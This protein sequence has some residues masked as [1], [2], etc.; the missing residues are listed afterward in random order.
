MIIYSVLK[1]DTQT[2][3]VIHIDGWFT[4]AL[5]VIVP[6][7]CSLALPIDRR[8]TRAAR[9][10]LLRS[11]PPPS[12]LKQMVW[13]PRGVYQLGGG[14]GATAFLR[15][16]FFLD[17]APVTVGQALRALDAAR[18][19]AQRGGRTGRQAPRA[20]WWSPFSNFPRVGGATAS[21]SALAGDSVLSVNATAQVRRHALSRRFTC[22]RLGL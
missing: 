2:L 20:R 19:G 16:G 15:R 10:A 21:G 5:T 18:R 3:E 22:Q 6:L 7:P 17:S 9:Q 4:S 13:V 1:S 14:G 12:R 8:H 11:L